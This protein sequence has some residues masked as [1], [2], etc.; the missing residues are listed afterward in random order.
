M[1]MTPFYTRHPDIAEK[2]FRTLHIAGNPDIPD[3]EYG[4]LE[5]YCD[6]PG[7]DCRRVFIIV[8][9]AADAT[10][11]PLATINY[12][13]E[14][15]RFYSKWMHGSISA[16]EIAELQGPALAPMAQQSRL[17]PKFLGLFRSMLDDPN[18][19]ARLRRHYSLFRRSIQAEASQEA[20]HR[21][22]AEKPPGPNS[23]CT[24]GSGKKYKKC[25]GRP[26]RAT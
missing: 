5:L 6:E 18:F 21:T 16:N 20:S 24:C 17:A 22:L 13:W 19:A 14:S 3:G 10:Q 7:C 23:V 11:R 8:L 12:G 1:P 26:Q 9:D 2:E 4:F 15:K 25:C